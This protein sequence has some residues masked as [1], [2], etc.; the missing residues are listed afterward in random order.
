MTDTNDNMLDLSELAPERKPVKLP[1]G[2][3]VEM[4][5]PSELSFYD[6]A[7]LMRLTQKVV[8]LT[9]EVNAKPTK[10]KADALGTALRDLA[11]AVL[12]DA[13]KETIASLSPVNLDMVSGAFLALYGDMMNVMAQRIGVQNLAAQ[14]SGS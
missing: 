3:V 13:P 8:G 11:E 6:R 14:T 2:N 1:D 7:Q 9:E 12:P 5:N 10:A 4:L